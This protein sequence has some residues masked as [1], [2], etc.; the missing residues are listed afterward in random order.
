MS[1]DSFA[2]LPSSQLLDK[3]AA[4][5]L[6]PGLELAGEV[7]IFRTR[8]MGKITAEGLSVHG[9]LDL[10]VKVNGEPVW[11]LLSVL[12]AHLIPGV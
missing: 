5:L 12:P 6:S 9:R 7:R 3:E 10:Q 11:R 4:V 8:D 1:E 2:E